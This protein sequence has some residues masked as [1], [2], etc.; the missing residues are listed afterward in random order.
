MKSLAPA[1]PLLLAA[2]GALAAA[3]AAAAL[4]YRSNE[5]A[6]FQA[7]SRGDN[8]A[9][10]A[11]LEAAEQAL[12]EG[13]PAQAATLLERA[14]RVEP[15]NPAV[16]HYLGLARHELGD[17][18]QAEAM[19]AKSLG[20]SAGDRGL[21]GRNAR[22]MAGAERVTEKP[23][24]VP[25]D[26]SPVVAL[27]RSSARIEPAREHAGLEAPRPAWRAQRNSADRARPAQRETA[28]RAWPA[29]RETAER[30]WRAQRESAERA[31]RAQRE[32]AERAWAARA[33]RIDGRYYRRYAS[34]AAAA[35][36]R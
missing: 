16:W 8:P 18:E 15:R 24:A 36:Q 19:A 2:L 6:P 14:L 32:R 3:N 23:V 12:R 10:L 11:L 35:P 31:W 20:L 28:E 17:Y 5:L 9:V 26:D 13:Q 1:L 33:A 7:A 27:Q 21:R 34:N 29:Q 4:E 22:L 30:A 25:H